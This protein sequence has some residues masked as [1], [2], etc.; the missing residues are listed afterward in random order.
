MNGVELGERI[1]SLDGATLPLVLVGLALVVV[2]MALYA[3]IVLA[4]RSQ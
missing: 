3:I 1:L 2:G 4:K